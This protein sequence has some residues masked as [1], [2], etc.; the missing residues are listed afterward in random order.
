MCVSVC[1]AEFKF[2]SG[3]VKFLVR[4]KGQNKI[5]CY[6]YQV[7]STDLRRLNEKSVCSFLA[8]PNLFLPEFFNTE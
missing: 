3:L 7:I 4:F 5:Q 2:V 8:S 1:S 6:F